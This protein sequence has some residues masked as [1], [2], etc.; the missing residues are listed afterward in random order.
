MN[1]NPFIKGTKEAVLEFLE[2]H[3]CGSVADGS[4]R[5][6]YFGTKHAVENVLENNSMENVIYEA[7]KSAVREFLEDNK[8]D[9]LDIIKDAFNDR[10]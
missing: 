3:R 9:I 8:H 1:E 7:V 10:F 2:N 4:E 5:M 6:F